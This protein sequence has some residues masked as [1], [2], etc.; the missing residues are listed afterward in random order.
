MILIYI[1]KTDRYE[2]GILGRHEIVNIMFLLTRYDGFS[3]NV[4]GI[5]G[6]PICGGK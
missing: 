3:S 4:I 5:A 6:R 2:L 1:L